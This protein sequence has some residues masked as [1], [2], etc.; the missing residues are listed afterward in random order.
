MSKVARRGKLEEMCFEEEARTWAGISI[1]E[2]LPRNGDF[3]LADRVPCGT[4]LEP[5]LLVDNKNKD[6]VAE[7]DIVKLVR[8]AKERSQSPFWSHETKLS[9]AKLIERTAGVAKTASEFCGR[10]GNG[11]QETLTC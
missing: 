2:K 5:R 10:P 8:D 3:I 7:S 11:Y 6:A 4:A 1:S 9:F